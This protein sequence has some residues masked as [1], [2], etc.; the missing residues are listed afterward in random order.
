M[1]E[2]SKTTKIFKIAKI[3]QLA[4]FQKNPSNFQKLPKFQKYRSIFNICFVVSFRRTVNIFLCITQLGFCCV[5]FVFVSQNLKRVCDHH[6]SEIDYHAYMGMVLLPMLAQCSIRNLRYLSPVSMLAN[7]LQF[8]GL[9]C[10]FFYLLQ[11]LPYSWE[12]KAF[13]TW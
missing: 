7:I 10:T 4:N 9:T 3:P 6:F 12:R 13:A 1:A 2:I 8:A 11:E 5:Y